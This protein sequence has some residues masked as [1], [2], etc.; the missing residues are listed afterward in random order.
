MES[1]LL[2]LVPR[3]SWESSDPSAL[4]GPVSLEAEADTEPTISLGVRASKFLAG[5]KNWQAHS[6]S[7]PPLPLWFY[8]SSHLWFSLSS[9]VSKH[10][11]PTPGGSLTLFAGDFLVN[12]SRLS[13]HLHVK[14][15]LPW[16]S[17]SFWWE[18]TCGRA[19]S[20]FSWEL[21]NQGQPLKASYFWFS[22]ILGCQ[23]TAQICVCAYIYLHIHIYSEMT[24]TFTYTQF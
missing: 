3:E 18:V 10:W 21:L 15:A 12:S 8:L 7:W 2:F 24:H 13:I 20:I 17:D 9:P 23:S 4:W 5:R 16:T 1:A 22:G 19:G 11:S 6:P 14:S